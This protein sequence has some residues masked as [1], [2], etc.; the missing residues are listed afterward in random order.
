MVKKVVSNISKLIFAKY[1]QI[2]FPREQSIEENDVRGKM[3]LVNPN[4]RGAVLALS[5]YVSPV[6]MYMSWA[7]H[8]FFHSEI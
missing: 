1:N 3:D 6:D 4:I 2:N 8:R 5:S 7:R